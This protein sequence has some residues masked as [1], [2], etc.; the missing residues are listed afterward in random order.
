VSTSLNP[1]Q[2]APAVVV[3]IVMPCLNE[4]ETLAICIRKALVAITAN[5]LSGEVV[6]A[7]NGSTD[8]SLGIAAAEGAR[9]INVPVRGYGAALIAGIEGA[10]GKYVLMADADDSYEFGHLPRFVAALDAGSDLVVGNRFRGEIKPGAMPPLHRYLGN[11]VLSALGRIFFSIPVGDFHCGI[12]AFRRDAIM[13]LGL[14]TTGMEFASEMVVKASLMGLKISEVPTTLYPDGRT[15]APHLRTWRDGWRHLRFL[16]LYS[17]RWLFLYPGLAATLIGFLISAW[18]LPSQRAIGPFYFDV[19]TL[20]YAIGLMLIGVH[21]CVFAVSAK[22]FGTREGFLPP[23]PQFEK[24]FQ[25]V[26]LE[27][28]L[29]TGVIL[30]LLGSGT[31]LYSVEVWHQAGFGALSASRSLRITL[32]AAASLMLGVEVIFA[33]FF[34]SLLGMKN[35]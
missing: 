34:L 6:I 29:L 27:T 23:N 15:R 20:T 28:G 30:L 19:N 8:G 26:T 4:A 12:R 24:L 17:P 25:Y 22:V 18:L 5:G 32:P 14:K 2:N 35:R 16:L 31:M 33:S 21:I 11:P 7:D 13:Q 3:T 9:V 1:D 10:H